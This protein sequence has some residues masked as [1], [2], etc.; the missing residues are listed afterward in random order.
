MAVS[1]GLELG[2][3]GLEKLP[4]EAGQLAAVSIWLLN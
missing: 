3:E 4:S 2:N 1:S